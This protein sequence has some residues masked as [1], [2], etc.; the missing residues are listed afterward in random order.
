[1]T[2]LFLFIVTLILFA[3]L[4]SKA[5]NII[6]K[7]NED[8]YKL[9]KRDI[10][11]DHFML[12]MADKLNKEFEVDEEDVTFMIY[13]SFFRSFIAAYKP[14]IDDV[15]EEKDKNIIR[16]TYLN[17]KEEFFLKLYYPFQS[18]DKSCTYRNVELQYQITKR[19]YRNHLVFSFANDYGAG[20]WFVRRWADLNGFK[21][22]IP[23]KTTV[24]IFGFK[25]DI[26]IKI[27]TEAIDNVKEKLVEEHNKLLL[28]N[29]SHI[30]DSQVLDIGV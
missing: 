30:I 8:V 1:M 22:V 26:K 6:I 20:A 13:E 12:L 27:T 25:G 3:S 4:D 21:S 2:K 17:K 24:E 29:L 16:E 11:T 28:I 23:W 18:E 5:S 9:Q 7:E 15:K 19:V 14:C 10:E